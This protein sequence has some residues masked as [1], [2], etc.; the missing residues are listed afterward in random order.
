M[1]NLLS[2]S[3]L[4]CSLIWGGCSKDDVPAPS[5]DADV[6]IP[7]EVF[8]RFCLENYDTDGDG[9]LS[10]AEARAVREMYCHDPGI[11]SMEGIE[12]FTRLEV[13]DCTYSYGLRGLDLSG[14]GNLVSVSCKDCWNLSSLN[15]SQCGALRKLNCDGCSLPWLDVT[16]NPV[17]ERLS[18]RGNGLS[19]INLSRN[20]ELRVV[21]LYG[22]RLGTLNISRNFR[23]E[24]LN[25]GENL[26]TLLDVSMCLE[27]DRLN[28]CWVP[29]LYLNRNQHIS[30]L[31][32]YG[33]IVYRD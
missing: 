17:L 8:R 11:G 22:N 21:D 12:R 5:Y 29:T 10:A 31:I 16:R 9:R 2:L 15:V 7:D 18:C 19:M 30:S 3:L 26:L 13:F 27:L 24:E 32:H 4:L 23:L 20:P 25:C 28:A 33:E 14:N 6:V 1:K